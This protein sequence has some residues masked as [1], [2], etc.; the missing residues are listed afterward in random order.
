MTTLSARIDD[1]RL[2]TYRGLVRRNRFV[3]V[4]RWLVP[5]G[6]VLV[7]GLLILQIWVM[8]IANQYGVS[9][10]RIDRSGVTVETP[11]YAG[12][13]EDGSRYQVSAGSARAPSFDSEVV[14]L[15][16]AQITILRPG[17][18]EM[19]AS[20]GTAVMQTVDQ[21]VTVTGQARVSDS[22]GRRGTISDA[23]IDWQEQTLVATGSSRFYM[24]DGTEIR[25]SRGVAYDAKTGIWEFSGATVLMFETP[26]GQ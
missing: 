3:A 4:L 12:V 9:A 19:R 10:I 1:R 23:V 8:S 17:G 22:G 11:Q 14:D 24:E 5:G 21:M 18:G 25:A 20:A 26:G 2:R 6:G 15:T 13:M 16:D 7:L